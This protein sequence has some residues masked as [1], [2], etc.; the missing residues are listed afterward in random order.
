MT[1]E[2]SVREIRERLGMSQSRFAATFGFS[3]STLRKWEQGTRR[4]EKS[5]E[6]LLAVIAYAPETVSAAVDKDQG[7]V[8]VA[9]SHG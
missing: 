3:I 6:I 4:P 1:A 7:R 2:S 8:A 5:A 9:I